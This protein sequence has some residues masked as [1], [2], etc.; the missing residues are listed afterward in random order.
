M[1]RMP[2]GK[3]HEG[4]RSSRG[5]FRLRPVQ[6]APS[7]LSANFARLEHEIREVEAAGAEMLHIDVMD[8]QFVPNLTVGPPVIK[9][10]RQATDMYLDVHLMIE[11]PERLLDAFLDAGSDRLTIHVESTKKVREILT[12]VRR[13]GKG[14]GITLRPG[15]PVTDVLPYLDAVDLLLIMTVEPGFG[16]QA[17]MGENLR[18]IP[19]A[20]AVREELDGDGFWI[21][22]DGGIDEKTI[23]LARAGGVEVYV[24]G[25]SIFGHEDRG[26]IMRSLRGLAELY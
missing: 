15:T 18:K 24:A 10:I 16:G 13:C 12:K 5:D 4:V 19:P 7:I 26:A 2:Q 14:A 20:L 6:L 11:E 3:E 23:G 1:S 21:Q 25:S 9:S 22:V 17:F 8:G